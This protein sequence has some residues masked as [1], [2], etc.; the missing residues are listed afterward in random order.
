ELLEALWRQVGDLHAAGISHGR[1]NASNIAV[2]DGEPLLLD[3]GAATL[4]APR[5]AI[6]ID[7]AELLVACTVLV[8]PDRALGAGVRGAGETPVAGAL[9]SLERGA[10]TPHLRDLARHNDVALEQLRASAATATHEQLP[11]IVP[12]R[13]VRPRD[14]VTTALVILAAYLLVSKLA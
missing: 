1:L 8:G 3:F 7:V 12:L 14:V 13:R 2:V 4:G 11:D 6:D 5:S 10:L 9:R